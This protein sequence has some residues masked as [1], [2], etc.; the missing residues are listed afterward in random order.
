ALTCQHSPH[1]GILNYKRRSSKNFF[2]IPALEFFRKIRYNMYIL[3]KILCLSTFIPFTL[4]VCGY[5]SCPV[6]KPNML[7]VHVICHTHDDVG[8]V[9]T[10]EEYYQTFV[11]HILN[12]VIRHLLVNET[13]KFIYVESAFLYRWWNEQSE[14][15]KYLIRKLIDDGQLEIISGGWSMNDEATTH[16]LAIIDQMTLGMRWINETFGKCATPKIG[17]Q[18]DP[19]GHSREQA[20]IFA[21][22]KFDGLFLGRIDYQ[23]KIFRQ[24]NR[25]LEFLWN[26]NPGYNLDTKLFTGI[27][28]NVYWPPQGFC[29]DDLCGEPEIT[30]FN[31]NRKARQLMDVI[32]YQAN[33][34][35]TNHTV[36]TMGMDFHYRDADR[37]FRNL[38]KLMAFINNLQESGSNINIFYST[39]SCYLHSLNQAN[40]TWPTFTEDFFPYA[41]DPDAYWT[42]YYSSKPAIKRFTR[43][44]NGFLQAC[45]QIITLSNITEDYSYNLQKAMGVMQHHDAVTGT[46]KD[47]VAKDYAAM[48]S[49]GIDDCEVLKILKIAL[50]KII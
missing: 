38:D 30:S 37:W 29:F 20:S 33:Y 43:Y 3:I 46:E 17:W 21:Q 22:M 48:L 16:Y 49:E 41:S 50:I 25:R 4:A 27:L 47:Y 5:E 9:R 18:I 45:K 8:W 34:Y 42:G 32:R 6:P 19:F 2:L 28:P 10:V 26:T 15:S 36:L 11:K 14:L 13:R 39:P 23:D 31:I 44:S 12:S 35:R 40:L 7:N 1:S 24:Q